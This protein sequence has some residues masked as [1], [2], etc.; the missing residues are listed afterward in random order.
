MIVSARVTTKVYGESGIRER[1][2]PL[3]EPANQQ[4]RVLFRQDDLQPGN[5]SVSVPHLRTL[6]ISFSDSPS[7]QP[8]HVPRGF[9]TESL[10]IL[11]LHFPVRFLVQRRPRP[12]NVVDTALARARRNIGHNTYLN[13]FPMRVGHPSESATFPHQ[14]ACAATTCNVSTT[15]R[16]QYL[17]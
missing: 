8:L 10:G 17:Y 5:C 4:R 16:A 2:I 12:E 15:E 9:G 3:C 6:S 13:V 7:N 14:H 1:G 11:S